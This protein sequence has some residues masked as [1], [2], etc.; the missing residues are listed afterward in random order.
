MGES[1]SP[2]AQWLSS[3]GVIMIYHTPIWIDPLWQSIQQRDGG[4]NVK[5]E[6]IAK[7][8]LLLDIP[9]IPI[10]N[11]FDYVLFSHTD[12]IFRKRIDLMGMVADSNDP[13]CLA[14]DAEDVG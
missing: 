13:D 5:R 8:W 2:M 6:D 3:R 10:L 11:F 1:T 4:L 14:M 9:M 12:V 7:L